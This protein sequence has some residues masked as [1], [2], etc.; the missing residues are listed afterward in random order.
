QGLNIDNGA[1]AANDSS[2]TSNSSSA[3]GSAIQKDPFPDRPG[4][5]PQKPLSGTLRD[6]ITMDDLVGK[7]DHGAGSVQRYVD[8]N[9]GNYAGTTTS[10]YGEQFVIR[11]NGTFDYQFVGRAN[12]STVRETDRGTI[13]LSGGYI[14]F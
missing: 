2:N 8:S 11:S 10:F 14:T 12:N 6:S 5:A 4:Y 3:Q 13:I 9:T 1:A 7:W